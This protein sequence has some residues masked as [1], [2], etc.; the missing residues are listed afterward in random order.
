MFLCHS[1][2]A[3]RCQVHIHRCKQSTSRHLEETSHSNTH[4]QS[5]RGFA[6]HIVPY[7]SSDK[8]C[9]L[10]AATHGCYCVGACHP[11]CQP[12][13]TQ[14]CAETLAV[15]ECCFASH[16]YHSHGRIVHCPYICFLIPI[17]IHDS[18]LSR[19]SP[20]LSHILT[21]VHDQGHSLDTCRVITRVCDLL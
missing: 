13:D 4:A 11:L 21:E 15:L 2:F 1:N 3:C 5:L 6:M 12:K 16:A 8:G 14:Q 20:G 19:P 9:T 18:T 17:E 7:N 10:F